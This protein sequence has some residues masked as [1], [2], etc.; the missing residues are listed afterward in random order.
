MQEIIKNLIKPVCIYLPTKMP[1]VPKGL[2]KKNCILVTNTNAIIFIV[3]HK[4]FS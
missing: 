1:I 3:E 2:I 4:I